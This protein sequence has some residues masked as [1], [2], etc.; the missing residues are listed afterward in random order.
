MIPALLAALTL[1]AAPPAPAATPAPGG[2]VTLPGLAYRVLRSGS[3][4][5][6]HPTRASR[7]TVRY[8]GRLPDGSV[9]NTS[10]DGGQG[11]T[12]FELQKLIPGWIA[13]L[14]LMRPGDLWELRVPAHLAYGARGKETIP[15]NTP[16]T[17]RVELVSVENQPPTLP[18]G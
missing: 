7:I 14:Q 10:P 11:T 1:A 5:G 9:F 16:L 12:T 4:E 3:A 17:F 6:A 13:A 8:E 2:L 15:P 18:A